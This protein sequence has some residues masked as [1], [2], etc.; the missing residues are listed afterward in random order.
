MRLLLVLGLLAAFGANATTLYVSDQLTVPLRRGPSN[1]YKII[2]A[3]LPSGTALDVLQTNEEAGFT[4]V[5]TQNGT[6]GWVPSQYLVSEPAARDRLAAATKRADTLEAELK[7]LR[8]TVQEQRS[9]RST[10]EGRSTDLSKQTE[11]LQSEL[12]ELRRVSASAITNYEENKQ[13]KTENQSLQSQ[14]SQLSSRVR[15]LERNTMLRW[16]LAGGG[17][18]LVGLALGAWI[19]SRPKR[20]NWA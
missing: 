9:A 17:L 19:K 2:N 6:E 20:S 10:A 4:Q 18:V 12:A 1:E 11:K 5:R 3:G 14:V 15:E 13:L 16:L 7:T 8:A